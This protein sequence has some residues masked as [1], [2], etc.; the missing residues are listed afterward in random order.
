MYYNKKKEKNINNIIDIQVIIIKRV[1]M[2]IF[3]YTL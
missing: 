2:I 3:M 1:L